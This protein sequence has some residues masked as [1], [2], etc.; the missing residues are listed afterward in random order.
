MCRERVDHCL[1]EMPNLVVLT[2]ALCDRVGKSN[3]EKGP[4]GV[5]VNCGGEW[6]VLIGGEDMGGGHDI[7]KRLGYD[8]NGVCV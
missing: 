7:L 8:A 6:I 5:V 3:A 2:G 1:G 4:F